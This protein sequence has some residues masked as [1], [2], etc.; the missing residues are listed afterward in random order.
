VTRRVFFSFHYERDSWRASVVRN[1]DVTQDYAGF[2]DSSD[3]ESL[4]SRGNTAIKNWIEEQL[5]GTSVTV[6]LIGAETNTRQWVK[7]ELSRSWMRDNGI[8]G[9]YIHQIED[10]NQQMDAKGKNHFGS[11][12][13]YKK[14]DGK[15]YFGQRF[16]TYNWKTDD[17]YN[18]FNTWIETAAQQA[19]K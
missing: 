1:S 2:I 10:Q 15:Q 14:D 11:L 6:V 5:D 17:G 9:I 12:F 16:Y 8:L 3:W 18:N 19:G 7:Y 4:K 13:K